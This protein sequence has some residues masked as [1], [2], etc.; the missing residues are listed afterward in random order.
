MPSSRRR[1]LRFNI[2]Y[3]QRA[4]GQYVAALDSMRRFLAEP[5]VGIAATR[6]A[7][8][9]G[10]VKELEA[11]VARL[12]VTVPPELR[13]D[14]PPTELM[15]DGRPVALD[16]RGSFRMVLDPGRHTVQARRPGYA[17]RFHDR[18]LRPGEDARVVVTLEPLPARLQVASNVLHAE[19][20]LDGNR[21]GIAPW[22]AEVVAGRHRVTVSAPGYFA[23]VSELNLERGGTSRVTAN[24]IEI[25][26]QPIPVYRR[27]WLW[28]G[29]GVAVA[30]AATLTYLLTRP[31]PLPPPYEPGS[32][33]WVVGGP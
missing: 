9:E 22:D 18:D 4:L 8:A 10:Y 7:E 16:E 26:P 5:S 29:V 20:L 1:F 30:G 19:V 28:T 17:P 13:T 21:V 23:H 24:L 27:W 32:L 3:C 2:G 11:R 6:R 33:N 25:P 14:G 12:Q 15:L 31:E